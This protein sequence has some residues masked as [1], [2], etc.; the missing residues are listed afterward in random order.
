MVPLTNIAVVDKDLFPSACGRLVFSSVALP[1]PRIITMFTPTLLFWKSP[2]LFF[3]PLYM[4]GSALLCW[5]TVAIFFPS[6]VQYLLFLIATFWSVSHD[7]TI[8]YLSTTS[9][10]TAHDFL[11]IE[12]HLTLS[13]IFGIC[14]CCS[15]TSLHSTSRW[16]LLPAVHTLISHLM[17]APCNINKSRS[18]FMLR[19]FIVSTSSASVQILFVL[20]LFLLFFMLYVQFGWEIVQ[21]RVSLFTLLS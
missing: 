21:H 17:N 13:E 3:S 4:T 5:F 8:L 2:D 19:H 14:F 11:L 7:N 20:F 9:I 12:N 15:K 6:I 1:P 18:S 10:Q 16:H